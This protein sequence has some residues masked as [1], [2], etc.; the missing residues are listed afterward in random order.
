MSYKV[1]LFYKY[2]D[3]SNLEN[4]LKIQKEVLNSL[5]L[6]GR[7]LIAAEGINGTVCG[8]F[9]NCNRYIEFMRSI[10]KFNDIDFKESFSDFICFSKLSVKIRNEIVALGEGSAEITFKDSQEKISPQEFHKI[11]EEQKNGKKKDLVVFDARNKY[12]SRIGKFL[13]ALTPDIQTSKEFDEYFEKNK[14]FFEGKDVIMYCTGGVRCERISGILSKKSVAKKIRH[15][16]GGIHRY[17]EKYPEGFF[18]G[19]NYVFDDR[20]SQKVNDDVLANCDICEVKCDLYNNCLNAFCNKHY[21]SCDDCLRKFNGNCSI[22]CKI[23]TENEKV[24]LRSILPSR[25]I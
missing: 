22:E 21:I 14:D 11:L 23:K 10:E 25:K 7:V 4:E 20:I 24:P 2:L 1:L 19:R 6:K 9:E 18:R 17:I 13:N 5:D 15:I 16:N 12:E 3:L 8:T